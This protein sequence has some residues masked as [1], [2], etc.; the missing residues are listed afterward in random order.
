MS[1]LEYNVKY[2]PTGFRKV[3]H[4]NWPLILLLIAVA[5]SAS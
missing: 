5:G 2:V 3:S 4:L 1:Y